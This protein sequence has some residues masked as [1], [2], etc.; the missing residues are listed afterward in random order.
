MTEQ[1]K[2]VSIGG[3]KAAKEPEPNSSPK[4]MNAHVNVLNKEMSL[5]YPYL[6]YV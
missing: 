5:V 2:V 4:E 3:A 6:L 1:L